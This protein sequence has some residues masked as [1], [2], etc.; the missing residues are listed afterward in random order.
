MND[1]SKILLHTCCGPCASASAE[2]IVSEGYE[3]ILY[4]ANSNIWPENEWDKRRL[5]AERLSDILGV[6]LF[7]EP[8]DHEAWKER[9][10]GYEK[11]PEGGLRCSACF[12]YN[13]GL[14]ADKARELGIERF[15]TSLT[16]SPHK[17]SPKIFNAGRRFDRFLPID[18]K[19]RSGYE[20]SVELSRRF[21]LYRQSYC[22]CEYSLR[23]E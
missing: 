10:L 3:P 6:G 7:I 23:K 11:E 4:Y 5:F 16:I 13:L 21:D 20:K 9:I 14:T 8:Y 12:I 2:R 17:N 19:K 15:T 22:G 18:F 1:G